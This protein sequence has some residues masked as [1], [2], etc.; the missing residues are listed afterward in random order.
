MFINKNKKNY[1][2]CYS[3]YELNS[4]IIGIRLKIFQTY[5]VVFFFIR[6]FIWHN[7]FKARISKYL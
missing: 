1:N 2:N 6:E 7:L 5:L 3:D 4:I